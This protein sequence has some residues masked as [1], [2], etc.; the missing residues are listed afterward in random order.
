[1]LKF[2]A[3]HLLIFLFIGG[4][5]LAAQAQN[6]DTHPMR[7]FMPNM[8]QLSS[9]VDNIDVSGGKL[10][11][12]IPLGSLPRGQGGIGFD[13]NLVY[14]SRLFDMEIHKDLAYNPVSGQ[15]VPY[16]Y[17][18]LKS[19]TTSGSWNYGR[20]GYRID[21]ELKQNVSEWDTCPDMSHANHIRY[22][23]VLPDGSQH[24]LYLKGY[25][26]KDPEGEG[27]YGLGMG[28]GSNLCA[29]HFGY[30]ASYTGW[31]T[32]YTNDG[33]H[34]KL[35]VY[36]DG[37]NTQSTLFL[38]DG[39]VITG[40]TA[41]DANGNYITTTANGYGNPAGQQI[42]ILYNT[43]TANI[44]GQLW[45]RDQVIAPGPNGDVTY[46]IDW[47]YLQ[48]GN[49]NRTYVI[50]VHPWQGALSMPLD[51]GFWVVKYIQLPLAGPVALGSA[52]LVYN[53]YEFGYWD[54][55]PT[56]PEGAGYGQLDY[57]RMPSGAE[58]HYLYEGETITSPYV[59]T[60]MIAHG[61]N[62]TRKTISYTEGSPLVWEFDRLGL[63]VNVTNPDG[64]KTKHTYLNRNTGSWYDGLVSKIEEVNPAGERIGKEIKRFWAQNKSY[65]LNGAWIT[66]HNPWMTKEIVSVPN[67]AGALSKSA[68]VNF[69][70]DKNGNLLTKT[71]YDWVNYGVET[72]STIKR[73]TQFD[74][75]VSLPQASSVVD[76]ANAYWREHN[77][78]LWPTGT[79]RRLNAVKRQTIF[80]GTT[81]KAAT[82]Y[83]YDSA[84]S[85]GNVTSQRR[86]DSVKAA[87][88]PSLGNLSSANSQVLTYGYDAYG[89]LTDKYEPEVRTHIAYDSNHAL[90]TQVDTGYGTSA[91]RSM[92]YAWL[93]GVAM[94]IKHDLQNDLK[95]TYAY[96]DVG[97]QTMARSQDG[98]QNLKETIT[99][100]RDELR[101]VIT[102]SDLHE[103]QDK[104]L[105]SITHYDKL[106]RVKQVQTSDGLPLTNEQGT[107]I[108][109]AGIKSQT[110]YT[111]PPLINGE[112]SWGGRMVIA[113]SP[114]RDFYDSTL[115]WTCTQHDLFGRV[116]MVSVFKGSVQPSSC[117][118]TTNRT[119]RS[120]TSYDSE[121]TI[122]T[123]P[124]E[125]QRKE[126]RDALGRLVEVIEDPAGLN[127][128]TT[129]AYDAMDN[130]TQVVQGSQVRTFS[131]SSL[132]RLLS[133]SNPESGQ[134]QY[135]YYDSGNL[136][137]KTDAR[138]KWSQNTYDPLQRVLTK[139]YSDTTPSVAY[140]YY[141]AGGSSA[142]DIGQLKS[143]T[144]AVS[145]TQYSYDALG[146]VEASAHTITGHPGTKYFAYEWYLNGAL[147]SMEYPSGRVVNYDVDDAGRTEK[148]YNGSMAYADMTA[149]GI[150]YPFYPDGR[151]AQMKLGNGR[152]E[153]HDFHTPGTAT[154][155]KLG[156]AVGDGSITQ[157]NYDFQA[158][159]NNGNVWKQGIIRSQLSVV[160][161]YGYDALNRISSI[162]ESSAVNRTYGYDRYGNRY[163]ATSSSQIPSP[164]A[165]EPTLPGHYNAANNRLAMPGTGFD[166]AGNQ[167]TLDPFTLEYDAEG[168]NTVVKLSGTPY[169]T[170]S[171]D[172]E[173]RRVKKAMNGGDTTY[174]VYDALG[175]MAVEYSTETPSSTGPSYLFT[176]MLGSVR[177]ITNNA[178]AVVECY[179][180]LPF[181]RMLGSGVGGRGTCYPDPPDA[182]YDSRA[183]QKFTGKERDAE[184]G[185]DYF[186][187][188]YY[189]GPEGRFLSPDEFN[190]GPGDALTGRDI[191]PSGPLP[192]ADIGNPQSLN[193]FS[194]VYNNPLRYIDPDGHA[195]WLAGA[196]VG[197]GMDMMV[198]MF[199]EGRSFGS[200]DWKS[201]GIAAATGAVG[202]GIAANIGKIATKTM[203]KGA[204]QEGAGIVVDSLG[205]AAQQYHKN[206]KVTFND[207]AIDVVV[208]VGAGKTLGTAA[209]NSA[210]ASTS[211]ASALKDSERSLRIASR[212]LEAGKTSRAAAA[213]EDAAI[214]TQQAVQIVKSKGIAASTAAAQ[215][216]STVAKKLEVAITK[217]EE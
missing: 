22:R 42:Q 9:P 56:Q 13:L 179:D 44:N 149:A 130:L 135:E 70:Y 159:T 181:G 12:Q 144:S 7:G 141:L 124:A 209:E 26:A 39:K 188:R 166:A 207:T 214:S 87:S 28:G 173:G 78:S 81:A 194:Y 165:P 119:G 123:D 40:A 174:Y 150:T 6:L 58:Y 75:Y 38:P 63:T 69:N 35:E 98:S 100:Y 198:Q 115:E 47:Q 201:V 77:T 49:D 8:D 19:I 64:G 59:E 76:N 53:S 111:Y 196:F 152:Y 73:K 187:A 25:E 102:T 216:G 182:N 210:K 161:E 95:T 45:K 62:I 101:I 177:T 4:A 113:S 37:V 158:T 212:R 61:L 66:P 36:A 43:A 208:G 1:M 199:V 215:V 86:W 109:D 50:G 138:G 185:L 140:E 186:L 139:T 151:I 107:W 145:S 23:V 178:G 21:T 171:Y 65:P 79:A 154:V 136:K 132:G 31:L 104:K 90:V 91:V 24:I 84:Y 52:P 167:T 16:E 57:M 133:A 203:A 175:Q 202:G 176:D 15:Q 29:Q 169:A 180:Y 103:H 32:Y 205:S 206:G 172:G 96:D 106:G 46:T 127:Y 193:K 10:N 51:F 17:A 121:W 68:I 116:M 129:Y 88:L 71:E 72:G 153:T 120:L 128:S 11:L 34:L 147:Q 170:F 20:P 82:E 200:I 143:V 134:T 126:K 131:Y 191:T 122:F 142:P 5:S 48:I 74:Y 183:P 148:A 117:E 60:A 110:S 85:K 197:A 160:Q 155:Y 30:P 2:G 157:I 190:G 55:D 3:R 108:V 192:Y 41:Y 97:R 99:D 67:A 93:N 137:K 213:L 217:K 184:T 195:A 80:E 189:S 89:N 168:R 33:S 27:Y 105:Q 94:G 54:N 162:Y 112:Y 18:Y 211:V 83:V 146:R 204:I 14:D 118:S 114:Y 163:V 164:I 92:S 156:V 125:R